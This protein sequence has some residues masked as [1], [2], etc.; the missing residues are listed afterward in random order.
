MPQ[1]LVILEGYQG[2]IPPTT[3][4]IQSL[5]MTIGDFKTQ[6]YPAYDPKKPSFQLLFGGKYL[7]DIDTFR[8]M[9]I[10]SGTT[11]IMRNA[12]R[13]SGGRRS[14]RKSRKSRKTRKHHRRS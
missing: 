2:Q 12:L 6:I 5:D 10:A 4:D 14:S 7:S 8:S 13:F 11:L 9:S 1:I 3:F